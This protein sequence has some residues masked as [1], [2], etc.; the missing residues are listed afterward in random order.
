MQPIE[1]KKKGI[2][3]GERNAFVQH[4]IFVVAL[5]FINWHPFVFQL[6][7]AVVLG[8]VVV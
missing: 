4:R 5:D 3:K 2:D 8:F 1:E 6:V 7:V